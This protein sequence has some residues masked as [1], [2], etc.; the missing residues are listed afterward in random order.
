M[1]DEYWAEAFVV[2]SPL[3]GPMIA[4]VLEGPVP[5]GG[6]I[7]LVNWSWDDVSDERSGAGHTWGG[8]WHIVGPWDGSQ[9]TV[10]RTPYPVTN[11][12]DRP[13]DATPGCESTQSGDGPGDFK[14]TRDRISELDF[15][16]IGLMTD[17]VWRW[18]GVCGIVILAII[19]S[20]E[21]REQLAPFA[22]D[23]VRWEFMLQP[24]S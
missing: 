22:S 3:H 14:E 8:P 18:D 15:R 16:D 17:N 23:I 6:D 7:A 4:Y 5:G 20:A 9:L 24:V 19:D 13:G 21:L 12:F 10:T 2:E 11:V 1:V